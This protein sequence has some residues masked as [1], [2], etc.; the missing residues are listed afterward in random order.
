MRARLAVLQIGLTSSLT[1]LSVAL[2]AFLLFHVVRGCIL[3]YEIFDNIEKI[4]KRLKI[5]ITFPLYNHTKRFRVRQ[6]IQ[7][8][9]ACLDRN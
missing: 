1:P 5:I 6:L 8:Q 3:S 2:S 9:V 7:L 4:K